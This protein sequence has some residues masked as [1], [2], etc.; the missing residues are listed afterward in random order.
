MAH[1]VSSIITLNICKKLNHFLF[2]YIENV[3]I[4]C[5]MDINMHVF[6]INASMINQFIKFIYLPYAM[7]FV[8]KLLILCRNKRFY[9]LQG[10]LLTNVDIY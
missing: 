4:I 3:P 1:F 7:M 6:I 8:A 10:G 5:A 9:S 2:I